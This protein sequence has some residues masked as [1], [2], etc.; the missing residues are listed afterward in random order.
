MKEFKQPKVNSSVLGFF[1]EQSVISF[2]AQR[3][4]PVSDAVQNRPTTVYF[5]TG[6]E[7]QLPLRD[8][9]TL[10]LPGKLFLG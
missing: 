8:E 1:V 5:S 9:P 7:A 4:F 10:Y 6:D 2:L 3:G